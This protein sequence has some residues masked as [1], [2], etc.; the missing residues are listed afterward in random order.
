VSKCDDLQYVTLHAVD[1]GERKATQGK[2]SVHGR[3]WL[4]NIW[5]VAKQLYYTRSFGTKTKHDRSTELDPIPY[6]CLELHFGSWMKLRDHFPRIR[7]I[8]AKTSWAGMH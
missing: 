2:S 6:S 5:R 4:T 8:L 3:N 7:S 1:K